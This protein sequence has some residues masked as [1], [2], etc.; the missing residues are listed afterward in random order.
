RFGIQS[1]M[2]RLTSALA[3]LAGR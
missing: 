1:A 2:D 3:K